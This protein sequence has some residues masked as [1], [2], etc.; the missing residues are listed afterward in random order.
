[1]PDGAVE[2][3]APGLG[4]NQENNEFC[5]IY[6][7]LQINRRASADSW[8]RVRGTAASELAPIVLAARTAIGKAESR[9]IRPDAFPETRGMNERG[10]GQERL[11]VADVF[12]GRG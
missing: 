4:D 9:A 3:A 11:S 6:K 1:M 5:F 12:N 10:G 7:M 8:S 2:V